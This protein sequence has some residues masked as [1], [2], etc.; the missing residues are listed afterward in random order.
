[1]YRGGGYI[2]LLI[3]LVF[4]QHFLICWLNNLVTFYRILIHLVV[5]YRRGNFVYNIWDVHQFI[6]HCLIPL[7]SW[8]MYLFWLYFLWFTALISK[9]I[10]KSSICPCSLYISTQE[11][12]K[13]FVSILAGAPCPRDAGCPA[14]GASQV[15]KAFPHFNSCCLYG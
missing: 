10:I 13:M 15:T 2:G 7:D 14:W 11:Y 1:M 9:C 8:C 4:Q 3:T 6:G 5:N 12:I